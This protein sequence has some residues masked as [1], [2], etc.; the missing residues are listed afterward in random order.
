MAIRAYLRAST[1]DQD[2]DRARDSLTRF[3]AE[4]GA[5][6]TAFYVENASGTKLNRPALDDLLDESHPG[7]VLLVEGIDRLTRLTQD[8]WEALKKRIE[9]TGLLICAKYVPMTHKLLT[10]TQG[11]RKDWTH[12]AT[13]K[14]LRGLM[15]ELAAAKAREDYEVRRERAEQGIARR[16]ARDAAG[17]TLRAGYAGRKADAAMHRKIVDLRQRGMT[18]SQIADMLGTTRPTI[19]RA[20]RAAGLLMEGTAE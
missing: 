8:D 4:H 16:K 1:A 13:E 12:D 20:L 19:A 15:V 14:A 17:E 3:V 18:Y 10:A 11:Q 2:A 6:I 7:D 9:D 5:S